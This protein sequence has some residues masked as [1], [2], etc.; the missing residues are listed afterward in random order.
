METFRMDLR[1]SAEQFRCVAAALMATGKHT[2]R[3]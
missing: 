2:E 3:M 1:E